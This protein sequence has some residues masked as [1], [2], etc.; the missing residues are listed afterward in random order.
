MPIEQCNCVESVQGALKRARGMRRFLH[1]HTAKLCNSPTAMCRSWR[2][3]QCLRPELSVGFWQSSLNTS[4]SGPLKLPFAP[5]SGLP[6]AC[7]VPS[8]QFPAL[9]TTLSDK[10]SYPHHRLSQCACLSSMIDQ[11]SAQSVKHR[12]KRL[13]SLIL[14]DTLWTAVSVVELL[15]FA[16]TNYKLTPSCCAD[17]IWQ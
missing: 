11:F 7:P 16:R 9:T 12:F 3:H 14:Q 8:L 2:F 5:V 6:S 1:E 4:L 17:N 15:T 13:R 10:L